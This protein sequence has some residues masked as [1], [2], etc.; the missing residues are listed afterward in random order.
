[1]PTALLPSTALLGQS[2]TQALRRH[3]HV[4]NHIPG[5]AAGSTHPRAS[6]VTGGSA[7]SLS[8]PWRPRCRRGDILA[9]SS[10]GAGGSVPTR[11]EPGR[12]D[13]PPRGSRAGIDA[14]RGYHRCGREDAAVT[15]HPPTDTSLSQLAL[16]MVWGGGDPYVP[17]LL[18]QETVP[19]SLGR[20]G[21]CRSPAYTKTPSSAQTPASGTLRAAEPEEAWLGTAACRHLGSAFIPRGGRGSW[22]KGR[23]TKPP[24]ESPAGSWPLRHPLARPHSSTEGKLGCKARPAPC[25]LCQHPARRLGNRQGSAACSRTSLCCGRTEGADSRRTLGRAARPWALPAHSKTISCSQ[26][27][28]APVPQS[29]NS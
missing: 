13:V 16:G 15:P 12:R 3:T 29:S 17:V 14:G 27:G 23:R 20:A 10:R 4:S 19:G 2:G 18:A 22:D 6:G 9:V 26:R 1:M 28:R 25:T 21:G 7:P 24:A 11:R 5:G 8:L